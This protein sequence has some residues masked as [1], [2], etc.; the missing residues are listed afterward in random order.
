MYGQFLGRYPDTKSIYNFLA[1]DKKNAPKV[2][3]V[4]GDSENDT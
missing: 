1:N 3:V 4:T 2:L